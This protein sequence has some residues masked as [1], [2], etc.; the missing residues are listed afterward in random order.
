[1]P[2]LIPSPTLIPC[3]GPAPKMILEFVGRAN[4]KSEG[5]SV[6]RMSSAPGWIEPGQTPEFDE[7]SL[8]ISG[9]LVVQ[10]HMDGRIPVFAGQAIICEAGEW[11]RYSTPDGAEYIS[12]CVPA[13]SPATVHRDGE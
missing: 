5:I 3:Q 13:F 12:I 7:I 9:T 2:R 6:A 1:M 10:T 11:V 8:V 4:T